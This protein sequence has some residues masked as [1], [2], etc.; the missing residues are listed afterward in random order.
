MRFCG[1]VWRALA[2]PAGLVIA[3]SG[4]ASG[5]QRAP[6]PGAASPPA[7][8]EPTGD[9]ASTAATPADAAPSSSSSSLRLMNGPSLRETGRIAVAPAPLPMTMIENEGTPKSP[10]EKSIA[11]AAS[12]LE[13]VPVKPRGVIDQR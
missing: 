7:T 12:S 8:A 3:L 13:P 5:Q 10:N 2:L 1:R 6:E 9:G 4:P 11:R